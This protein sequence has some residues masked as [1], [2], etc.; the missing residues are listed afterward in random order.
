M[1]KILLNW[2]AKD[3]SKVKMKIVDCKL[4]KFVKPEFNL[5][6]QDKIELLAVIRILYETPV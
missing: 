1:K 3:Y 6:T 4:Q 5:I 2:E